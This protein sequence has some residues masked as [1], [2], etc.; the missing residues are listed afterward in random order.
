M[1]HP[2][3]CIGYKRKGESK[4]HPGQIALVEFIDA[5]Y[6]VPD[7]FEYDRTF[8]P[9]SGVCHEDRLASAFVYEQ[10]RFKD[11]ASDATREL[12]PKLKQCVREADW[13]AVLRELESGLPS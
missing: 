12:R 6:E 8:G 5:S 4:L 11:D 1:P 9:W 13:A 3:A 2:K 10:L 7:N